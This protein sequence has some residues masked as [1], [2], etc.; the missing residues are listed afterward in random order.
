MTI[1][2]RRVLAFIGLVYGLSL[3]AFGA[4]FALGGRW[5]A[6]GSVV[7]TIGYMFIPM[8]AALLVQKVI[9]GEPVRE[10]MRVSFRFNRWFVFAWL[11]PPVLAF[12]T[13]GVGLLLP[14]VEYS[15]DLSGLFARFESVLEPEQIAR[16]QA[17]IEAMAIHPIWLGLGQGLLAGITVNAVA[18]FG[19]ELGWRGFL[20]RELEPLG[21]WRISFVI[22]VVWGFW[23]APII[24]QGH[25]Y[26]EHPVTGVFMMTAFTILISPLFTLVTLKA[27]SVIAASILHGTV[28]ATGG[29]AILVARGG[30]DLSVG[31]T[32]AAGLIVLA[33]TN[34]AILAYMRRHEALPLERGIS[35]RDR[36]SFPDR[37]DTTGVP[38]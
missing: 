20:L 23:H 27:G 18:A 28:N 19:E 30:T 15:P 7:F 22:G 35:P 31:L 8:V 3:G 14:G 32:G 26:P 17:D 9:H 24:L 34:L 33:A 29:L 11:T 5:E 16:M 21:F 38:D 25:N 6:P 2:K 10:P 13:L 1:R 12:A 4:Y 36:R 37:R